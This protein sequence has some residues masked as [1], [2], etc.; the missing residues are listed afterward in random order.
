MV[1]ETTWDVRFG[2]VDWARVLY[3][4]RLFEHVS[5]IVERLMEER[6]K[7]FDRLIEDWGVAMPVVHAEA[8]YRS[9]ITI[10]DRV[11]IEVEP[12][13]G[14]SSVQFN[15]AGF[16]DNPVFEATTVHAVVDA[17]TFES[18]PVPDVITDDLAEE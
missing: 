9:P 15:V 18:R 13:L 14:Q 11:R 6:A 2:D 1:Y 17:D 12:V 16:V 5:R 7:S 10:G 3:H 4:P 8:D